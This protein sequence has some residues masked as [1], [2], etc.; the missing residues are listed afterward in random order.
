MVG[1]TIVKVQWKNHRVG[2]ASVGLLKVGKAS[3]ELLKVGKAS[4]MAC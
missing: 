2:K 1:I 4:E 3:V